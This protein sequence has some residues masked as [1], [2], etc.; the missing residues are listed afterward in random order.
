MDQI[1]GGVIEGR[2]ASPRRPS[3]SDLY[4]RPGTPYLPTAMEGKVLASGD[5]LWVSEPLRAFL[6]F[7]IWTVTASRTRAWALRFGLILLATAF[8]CRMTRSSPL[9][10]FQHLLFL[11]GFRQVILVTADRVVLRHCE[12]PSIV[13]SKSRTWQW[14][15]WLMVLTAATLTAADP[16]PYLSSNDASHDFLAMDGASLE[17]AGSNSAA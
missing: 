6:P 15:V 9:F 14:M 10:A 5:P 4:G 16:V 7:G 8:I 11:G 1:P 13:A 17:E 2:D 3:L 12:D